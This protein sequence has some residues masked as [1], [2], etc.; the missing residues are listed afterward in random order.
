MKDATAITSSLTCGRNDQICNFA[1][2]TLS[3]QKNYLKR[4]MKLPRVLLYLSGYC[5]SDGKRMLLY[6]FSALHTHSYTHTRVPQAC[7]QKYTRITG[8][9]PFVLSTAGLDGLCE[10]H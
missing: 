6:Q 8:V 1:R 7:E 9:D 4:D 3:P 2:Y 5:N 10:K